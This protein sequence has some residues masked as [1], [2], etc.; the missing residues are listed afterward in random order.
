VERKNDLI[1]LIAE[2]GGQNVMIIDSSALT[3]QVVKDVIHSA[4]NS[5]GQRCSALRLLYVQDE[6]YDTT[7]EHLKGAMEQLQLGNPEQLNTDIASVI[8][9][10]AQ[11]KL[12]GYLNRCEQQGKLLYQ[13]SAP[14]DTGRGLFVAPAL[15]AV[16]NIA[17]IDDEYFGPV[18]HI[19]RYPYQDLESVIEQINASG[20][21]LTFGIQSRNE[22]W[23][24][25]VAQRIRAGNCY[26]NR[27]MVGARVGSQPFGGR[28]LSGSGPKAGGPNYLQAFCT[29]YCLSHNTSALG[30]DIELVRSL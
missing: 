5:A 19:A 2:T 11:Q 7:L 1:P 30:G 26:I 29:E 4:F 20:F 22:Y 28:G 15:V 13:L 17:A 25:E 12:S 18:L 21:G 16:E 3:E 27:N 24:A 10:S 6:V 8:D 23:A 14:T 9:H